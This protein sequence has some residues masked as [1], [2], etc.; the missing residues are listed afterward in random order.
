MV[1][2][3]I[4]SRVSLSPGGRRVEIETRVTNLARDH[5]LQVHFPT[6]I[7]TTR[8][9]AEGS[10]DVVER[11]LELPADTEDW[12][13]QPMPTKPQKSFVDVS[14]GQ[15]GLM[16]ANRGLPEYEVIPTGQGSTVALTL[17]RC[18]GWLSRDDLTTR[19]GHAGPPVETPEAQ[20]PGEH[21]FHYAIIPHNGEWREAYQETHAF[22]APLQAVTTGF[23]PGSLPMEQSFLEIKPDS[24]VVSAVKRAEE[25]DGLIVRFYNITGERVRGRVRL[26][27]SFKEGWRVNLNEEKIKK[28]TPDKKG[29]IS[30]PVRGHE[31]VTLRFVLAGKPRGQ[32]KPKS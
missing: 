22:N 20:C 6:P 3:P 10:F 5:R 11:P 16:V 2:V 23:H 29:A 8:S 28:L 13:E 32:Q 18:V 7:A 24:L 15:I 17:L 9:F 21:T 31:I 1:E 19:V 26:N 30:L 14:D 25:G 4:I 27:I 12:I